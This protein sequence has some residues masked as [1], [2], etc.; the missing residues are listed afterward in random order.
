MQ[1]AHP[2]LHRFPNCARGAACLFSGL[3]VDADDDS[4]LLFHYEEGAWEA[5]KAPNI[6]T[7]ESWLRYDSPKLA[8][9]RTSYR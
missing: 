2:R 3:F 5:L 9:T 4:Y 8:V 7:V 1:L 6:S